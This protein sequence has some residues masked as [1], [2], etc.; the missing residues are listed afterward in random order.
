[1]KHLL[2]Q[3]VDIRALVGLTKLKLLQK[4]KLKKGTLR[5]LAH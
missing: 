3:N 5:L 2:A 1:M 4:E